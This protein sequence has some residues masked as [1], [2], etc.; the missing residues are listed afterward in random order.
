MLI[1]GKNSV[2]EALITKQNINSITILNKKN[3]T[4]NDIIELAKQNN[5]RILIKDFDF[6]KNK[7]KNNVHQGIAAEIE[8]IKNIKTIHP[9][10]DAKFLVILDAIEDPMNMGA[11]IRSSVL[12]GIDGIIMIEHKTCGITPSVIKASSGALF[13]QN[14]YIVSNI[15]N[16]MKKLKKNN[17]W[18]YGLD[19]ETDK[20]INKISLIKNEKVVLII[21]S[22]GK[23]MHKLTRE[24]CDFIIKIPTTEKIDSLNASNAATIA[25]WEFYKRINGLI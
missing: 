15:A 9:D 5:I 2:K 24:N 8:N 3:D 12:F 13:H 4:Y 18:L 17:Y 6:F 14:I 25:M 20:D 23:G 11:I 10:K 22:E 21:G 7:L 1:F 16:A 19:M